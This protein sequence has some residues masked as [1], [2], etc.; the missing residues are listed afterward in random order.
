MNLENLAKE[1][2]SAA[3]IDFQDCDPFG[4]LNNARYLNYFMQARTQQLKDY[5]GFDLYAH[6]ATTGN[7]WVVAQTHLAYLVPAN[8]MKMS[9]SGHACCITTISG[10]CPRR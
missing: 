1:P 2:E 4:H 5:Y 9:E 8:S 10:W 6:T 7:G 3:W